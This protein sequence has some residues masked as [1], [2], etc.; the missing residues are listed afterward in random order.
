[1]LKHWWHR[2]QHWEYWSVGIIYTAATALWLFYA[3]RLGKL[4]FYK[5]LNPGM[6]NGGLFADSKYDMY[7][8]LPTDTFPKTILVKV[9]EKEARLADLR[10]ADL[11]YPLIVKPDVG[12]RGIGVDKV[13]SFAD[14]EK[15]AR[16]SKQDFL[17]Q[18]L[19]HYPEELGL[20]YARRPNESKGRITGLTLKKFL[21][22]EGDGQSTLHDLL[23]ANA[24]FALQIPKLRKKMDLNTVLEKGIQECLVPFGNHSRGTEF[25][26]GSHLIS[27]ELE[28]TFDA[29]LSKVPG[30]Y[31][32]RLDI[33][34]QNL[35][36]LAAGKNF[37]IIEVNGAKSEP[38]SIYDQKHSFWT[39]QKMILERQ[40]MVL[41]IVRLNIK[42]AQEGALK[43]I[44]EEQESHSER[45]EMNALKEDYG[46]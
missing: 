33:R 40:K 43:Q 22:V 8:L 34:Y 6:K 28:A 38:I 41:E 46:R 17:I 19:I 20:F 27:P 5:Y 24:R 15:Y 9:P 14:L 11:N 13:H 18:E 10:Q 45:L 37:S 32:G 2:T 12:A 7:K 35:E 30:F 25:I 16:R 36:D 29:I 44:A 4:Q 39:A 26:D 3:F 1:M 31:Y 23:C 21:V 42:A